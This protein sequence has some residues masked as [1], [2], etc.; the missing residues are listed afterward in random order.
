MPLRFLRFCKKQK[1][2][3]PER[4]K[5][6]YIFYAM[7]L[8]LSIC[9][10]GP[11][12]SGKRHALQTQLKLWTQSI[13]QTFVLKKQLWDA[14]LHNGDAAEDAADE[15]SSEK[16]LLPM[17]V[18]IMHWGFDVS[19]M[20]LQDKQY[21]KSILQRWGR[22]SQVLSSTHSQRCLVFYHAH[23]LSSESVLFLQAFLEENY[24]DTVLWLTSEHPLPPRLAD[25]CVE[26]PVT[27]GG[28][29]LALDKLKRMSPPTG[30]SNTLMTLEEEILVI[31]KTWMAEP[32]LL[33]DVKKI[34]DLVYGFLHRNIRWVDG[35]HQ[36]MFALELL[37]LTQSQKS[38]LAKI[39]ISQPF[40]GPGQTVPSYRI[41]ILWENY[42]LFI[43]NAL[44]PVSASASSASSASSSKEKEKETESLKK[45][46]A[47]ILTSASASASASAD[48]NAK[49]K[50][51]ISPESTTPPTPKRVYKKRSPLSNAVP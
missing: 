46:Q 29:D 34:R 11:P 1:A 10:R 12:G 40:T 45:N 31:Y 27:S 49:A 41:P 23:L 2:K 24:Q 5:Q 15:E 37:P 50:A 7:T 26:L 13:G 42:L 51:S 6:E 3:R 18:S 19:R 22:G 30:L 38:E 16:A 4:I 35:F 8:G 32:P 47:T 20:S 14:P 28:K 17:E 39:C 33:S 48:A 9:W 36:L 43:R 21:V 25:W 44:A